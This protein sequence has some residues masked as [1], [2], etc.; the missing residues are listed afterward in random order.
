MAL[1][2]GIDEAPPLGRSVVWGL[3]H[4]L[5]MFAGMVAVPL[6]V[7]SAIGL[8]ADQRTILVQGALLSS[9]V[10][11]LLQSLGLGPVGARLPIV[12][13]TAFVFMAP[14]V[15]IGQSL[16]LP[17]IM[18]AAIVGGLAELAASL[19]I[20]RVRGLF[21]P[22]VTG[23]VVT[24]IGLGLVPLGF[25]WAAGGSGPLFGRPVSFLLAGAVL[26]ALVLVN[27]WGTQLLR[28]TAVVVAVGAGYLLAGLT[29]HLDLQPVREAPWVAPPRLFA[30]G[31]PEFHAPAIL[32]MLVAQFASLLET[33]GDTFA[34]GT[35][36]GREITS[37][38]LR[39]A[40]MVDGLGSAI[41]PLLNGLPITSFSQNI[42]VIGIT[43][44]ASRFVTAAAGLL[45]IALAL[46]PK[47]A[48]LIT[49][50]PD[51][52]LGGGA[53][54]M[55]GAV[56]AAG[57]SQL[58]TIELTERELLIFSVA[59][60]VGLGIATRPPEAFQQLPAW[61]RVIVESSVTMGGLAAVVLNRLLPATR[62]AEGSSAPQ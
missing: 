62:P 6:V 3:Q 4:V 12:M 38:H 48:A 34:T 37:R 25:A 16:G 47:F 61:L 24:L 39:G 41:A 5:A 36:T 15:G 52:V 10:G 21:P 11:S 29:G 28:A 32:A 43:G 8:P 19:L 50:M 54:V 13:G 44:V 60:A 31:P 56:A 17:A 58:R 33:L 9:G 59:V 30:F 46:L 45:L 7:G 23:T 53:L 55:F 42:G 14:M 40:I 26:V 51:P 27:R 18:G 35:V 49:A 1:L 57:V 22:L 2:V 20:W